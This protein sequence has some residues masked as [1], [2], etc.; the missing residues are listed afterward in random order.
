M[1]KAE[2][3]ARLNKLPPDLRQRVIKTMLDR[4]KRRLAILDKYAY[5]FEPEP[6][7]DLAEP[8]IQKTPNQEVP[9]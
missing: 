5:L 4:V 3:R 2:F 9:D 6:E 1:D 7:M 8:S